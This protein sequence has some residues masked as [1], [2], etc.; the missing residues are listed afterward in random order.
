MHGDEQKELNEAL[1][2]S[3]TPLMFYDENEVRYE[4][5][6]RKVKNPTFGA[7]IR[8]VFI[9]CLVLRHRLR[10]GFKT[11]RLH[12]VSANSVRRGGQMT[13]WEG[14]PLK[15]VVE[16]EGGAGESFQGEVLAASERLW[17]ASVASLKKQT[18]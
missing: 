5:L 15:F 13:D 4:R 10:S 7:I 14:E 2:Y 16:E 11:V 18:R 9:S 17:K 3:T 1:M 6:K 12:G 8:D